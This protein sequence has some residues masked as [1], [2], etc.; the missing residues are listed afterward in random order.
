MWY[1]SDDKR[2]YKNDLTSLR[3]I[4]HYKEGVN[5]ARKR[6]IV[7][8]LGRIMKKCKLSEKYFLRSNLLVICVRILCAKFWPK[9]MILHL[10]TDVEKFK[11]LLVTGKPMGYLLGK[12]VG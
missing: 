11:I 1:T 7:P 12:P 3:I 6:A 4:I 8:R 9:K 10:P 2:P 5:K